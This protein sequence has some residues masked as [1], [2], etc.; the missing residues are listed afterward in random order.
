M[1][2]LGQVAHIVGVPGQDIQDSQMRE[3]IDANLS[4]LSVGEVLSFKRLHFEAQTML[5][6][7]LRQSVVDPD[8]ASKQKLPDAERDQRV[9]LFKDA[10]PGLFLDPTT[11]PGHSLLELTS[12]QERENILRHIPVEKCVSRQHEV[13][14]HRQPSKV[15]EVESGKINVKEVSDTPEPP[16]HGA[17]AFLEALKR[18]GYAYNMARCVSLQAYEQ[19]VA[20]LLMNFRRP[21]P[22]NHSRVSLTQLQDADKMVWMHMVERGTRPRQQADGTCDMDTHLHDALDSYQVSALLLPLPLGNKRKREN[23]PQR[24]TYTGKGKTWKGKGKGKGGK[25]KGTGGDPPPQPHN[26]AI[27]KRIKD[28]GGKAYT[29]KGLQVCCGFNL[30]GCKLGSACTRE[31]VCAKC[32]GDHPITKCPQ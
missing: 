17:L 31:H 29:S 9:K 22:P 8:A 2:T 32:E 4:G 13:L 30:E 6:A 14:N 15:L 11:E 26:V 7:Q 18:R 19:Y 3:W 16:A 28:L 5:I 12:A 25:G 24:V 27:P 10:N 21:A 20:K 1:K 23:S